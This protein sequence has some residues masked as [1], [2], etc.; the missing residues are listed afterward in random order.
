MA[1]GI[2][3]GPIMRSPLLDTFHRN[4]T[5]RF[6]YFSYTLGVLSVRE[7]KQANIM[8]TIMVRYALSQRSLRL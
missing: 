8:K 7:A 1:P 6:Y 4:E 2:S 5:H 3:P